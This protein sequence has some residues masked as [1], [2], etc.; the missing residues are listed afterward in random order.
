VFSRKYRLLFVPIAGRAKI[1]V[2]ILQLFMEYHDGLVANK[3][4]TEVVDKA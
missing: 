2:S 4:G 3:I 1:F